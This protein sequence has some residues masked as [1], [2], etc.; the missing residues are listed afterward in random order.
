MME[1]ANDEQPEM[2]SLEEAVQA[3]KEAIQVIAS[4]IPPATSPQVS[5]SLAAPAPLPAFLSLG[6]GD[7]STTATSTTV[8]SSKPSL[9]QP[10]LPSTPHSTAPS[11]PQSS[12]A[13]GQLPKAPESP[14]ISHDQKLKSSSGPDAQSLLVSTTAS[15]GQSLFGWIS[16]NSL[17]N[18]VVEKTKSS[19]ESVIT[20]LDPGMKELI[21]SGGDISIIVASSKDSKVIPVREAFQKVFGKATVTGKESQTNTAAQPVG[22]TAGSKGAEERISY[23]L[24]SG[25]VL[26][27]Q[28]II[29]V[30][31]FI[32]ELLPDRWCELSCLVL[33]DTSHGI[34]LQTFSQPTPIPTEYVLTAQDKTSTDYPLRWAGLSVTIGEVIEAAQPHIGHADWQ[35]VLSGVSRSQ[36]LF[37]AAQSLAYM[38]KQQ[39]PTSFV[40]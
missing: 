37:L 7:S 22:F 5:K 28:T 12:S 1:E 35:M 27:G 36:S 13:V 14:Q 24:R 15:V 32:V 38:Y 2:V 21:Y 39:L 31:G 3:E 20:T 11:I 4:S 33:K 18:R 23:L 16:N 40:S 29:A 10:S 19:M 17:V 6:S 26:D 34:D 25:T 8:A 30:E 9:P